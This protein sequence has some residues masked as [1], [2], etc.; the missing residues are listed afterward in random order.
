MR[1]KKT[2]I[3]WDSLSAN[4]EDLRIVFIS[5]LHIN[6][7]LPASYYQKVVQKIVKLEPD[8]ILMGG[9]YVDSHTEDIVTSLQ[10]LKPLMQFPVV[11]VLGNHDIWESE[12]L[13]TDT[14]TH[15]GVILLKNESQIVNIDG[16]SLALCGVEDLYSANPNLKGALRGIGE[17]DFSILLSHSPELYRTVREEYRV[18]LML[19]GHSHGGQVT[20]F[21]LWAPILPLNDKS[22]WRGTYTSEQNQ[23]IVTNG[24]GVYKYPL[25]VF[26]APSIELIL[27]SNGG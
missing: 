19:S 12:R 3:E 1:V 8:L 11:G 14:L 24:I 21:G 5:D 16:I 18:D 6:S 10:L 13:V 26:A 22:Y 17:A 15:L 20:L 27:L 4:G 25:R 23:L 9:D 7:L 2:K